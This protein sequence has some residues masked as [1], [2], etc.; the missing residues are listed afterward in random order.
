MALSASQTKTINKKGLD[1]FKIIASEEGQRVA[2]EQ[3]VN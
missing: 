2:E 3:K 1:P